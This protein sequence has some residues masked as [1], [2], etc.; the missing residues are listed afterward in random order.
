MTKSIRWGR[1][2][3]AALAHGAIALAIGAYAAPSAAITVDALF[4]DGPGG[5]GFAPGSV[6]HL[7]PAAHADPSARWVLAG[8]SGVGLTLAVSNQLSSLHSNPQADGRTPSLTDPLVADSTWTVRN[9]SGAALPAGFLVFTAIDVDRVYPGL[10][11]GLDGALLDILQYSAGGTEYFFGAVALPSLGVG[12]SVDLTVR[13]V[14][15]GPLDYDAEADA[16]ALPRLG[17]AGL[18]VPEPATL[19]ALALGLAG[20]AASRRRSRR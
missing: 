16:Y 5:F 6:A 1:T 14:V 13:Y 7:V 20:L 17:I 11:A 8:G 15:A 10:V 19:A 2:L 3:R 9:V 4:F 12:Q 18:L